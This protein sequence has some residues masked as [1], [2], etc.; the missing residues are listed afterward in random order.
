MIAAAIGHDH[1]L[2]WRLSPETARALVPGLDPWIENGHAF[3]LF[4][5]AEFRIW[6]FWGLPGLGRLH[7]AS[8]L[9]PC[10]IDSER[11]GNAFI[12]RYFNHPLLPIG[13]PRIQLWDDGLAVHGVA[14]GCRTPGAAPD[15]LAWFG[16]DRC[17]L[18]GF[19]GAW[20]RWPIAKTDWTWTVHAASVKS[21]WAEELGAQPL[22]MISVV[23]TN[24]KWARPRPL[25]RWRA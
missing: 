8:W 22:G 5:A 3:L 12:R 7:V 15:G 9:V 19:H 16:R 24:A 1:F 6:R 17:G 20:Q 11:I 18:V 13:G 10:R 14:S 4:A 21:S 2:I 23:S 25:V